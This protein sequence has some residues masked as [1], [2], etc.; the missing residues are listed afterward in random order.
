M[1]INFFL[2]FLP[3]FLF[4]FLVLVEELHCLDVFP[5]FSCQT[6]RGMPHAITVMGPISR[7][8]TMVT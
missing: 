3:V 6:V 1:R 7:I 4:Y 8:S 5:K 2:L